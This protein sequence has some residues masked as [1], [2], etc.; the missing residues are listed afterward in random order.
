MGR[1]AGRH[2]MYFPEY[3]CFLFGFAS[4]RLSVWK[5]PGILVNWWLQDMLTFF[6]E[7]FSDRRGRKSL[8]KAEGW[9]RYK[10]K[11]FSSDG[12]LFSWTFDYKPL[13][14]CII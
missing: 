12:C 9:K 4:L 10:G 13:D 5:P 3:D 1:A 14:G 2:Q 11:V 8:G 6:R 7:H